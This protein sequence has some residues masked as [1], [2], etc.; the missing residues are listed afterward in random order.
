M[1]YE[2]PGK[3]FI[4]G[5]LSVNIKIRIDHRGLQG[6]WPVSIVFVCRR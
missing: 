1:V 4:Q 5:P 6:L 3:D 2:V